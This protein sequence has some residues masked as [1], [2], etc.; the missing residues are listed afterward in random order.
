MIVVRSSKV[1]L[2]IM[3][4]IMMKLLMMSTIMKN[5]VDNDFAEL[6]MMIMIMH[7]EP[8][9]EISRMMTTT[10]AMMTGTLTI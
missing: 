4:M 5:N 3:S 7:V 2:M 6:A 1:I 8:D 10:M 9:D